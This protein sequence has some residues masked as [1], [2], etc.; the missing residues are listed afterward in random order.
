M[1]VRQRL[2]VAV[3]VSERG[4]RVPLG[5]APTDRD[6]DA[7]FVGVSVCVIVTE[8]LGVTGAVTVVVIVTL[9]VPVTVLDGV[10]EAV[11]VPVPVTVTVGVP[12]TVIE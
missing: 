10:F 1:G 8:A 2:V 5:V 11:L 6:P 3:F 12:V 4:A 9:V 7:V